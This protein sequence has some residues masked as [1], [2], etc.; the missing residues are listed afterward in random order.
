MPFSI[1]LSMAR[2]FSPMMMFDTECGDAAIVPKVAGVA[3]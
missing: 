3:A 2:P 1:P